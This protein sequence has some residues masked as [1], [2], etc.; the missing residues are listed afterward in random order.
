ME[1]GKGDRRRSFL[2]V[3]QSG[4][5]EANNVGAFLHCQFLADSCA[6]FL[7]GVDALPDEG[8]DVFG[9]DVGAHEAAEF[10]F[11]LIQVGV[12]GF[13][14]WAEVVVEEVDGIANLF[15]VVDDFP[16]SVE[17]YIVKAL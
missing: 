5:K 14:P 13:Q 11:L 10:D 12:G 6:A 9:V 3:V 16:G 2:S 4:F 8:G 1:G 7:D 15:A 17:K